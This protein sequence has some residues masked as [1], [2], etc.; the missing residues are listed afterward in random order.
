MLRLILLSAVILFSFTL[1]AQTLVREYPAF[2]VDSVKIETEESRSIDPGSVARVTLY[3]NEEGK[4]IFGEEG[5]HG[6]IF[7][8]TKSYLKKKSSEKIP[9]R[10]R[11]K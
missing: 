11:K 6:V 3:K 7:I 4:K 9:R 1:K 5:K 8:E 2:Y 10:G